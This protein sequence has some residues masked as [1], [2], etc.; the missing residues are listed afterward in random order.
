MEDWNNIRVVLAVLEHRTMSDAASILG[1]STATVSRR[2]AAAEASLGQAL[3]E[4]TP[5]GLQPTDAA[6]AMIPWLAEADAALGR[7]VQASQAHG[8]GIAG[9]VRVAA[10]PSLAA[11]VICPQL[12]RLLADHPELQVQLMLDHRVV[13]LGRGDADIAIRSARPAQENLVSQRIATLP[14][15]PFVAQSLLQ[16]VGANL[17]T[18]PWVAW[19]SM[20]IAEVRWFETHAPHA[21][22]VLVVDDMHAQARACEAGVGAAIMAEPMARQYHGLVPVP[23]APEGYESPLWMATTE[24]ARAIP[25]VQVVWAFLQQLVT[26]FEAG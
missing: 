21:R 6:K 18:L 23:G 19:P 26:E 9:L 24:T 25:R 12:P 8:D 2:L 11:D 10:L 5:S 13:N 7:A 20:N 3:V 14:T 1:V 22:V 4:R 15:R 16:R 17:D